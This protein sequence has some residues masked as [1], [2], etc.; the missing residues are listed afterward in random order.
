MVEYDVLCS[1]SMEP[2]ITCVD[3]VE[4]VQDAP[5]DIVV[6]DILVYRLGEQLI[7][8]R[9]ALITDES[10]PRYLMRGD[11]E[12]VHDER[13]VRASQVVGEVVAVRRNSNPGNSGTRA[14]VN[15]ARRAHVLAQAALQRFLREHCPGG[16]CTSMANHRQALALT[17]ESRYRT[18]QYNGAIQEVTS[19]VAALPCPAPSH[20]RD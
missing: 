7:L 20:L 17:D 5:L 3:T 19:G 9:V 11:N 2:A 16:E 1:G 12:D 8:H 13:L 14:M 10:P 6:G 18:C 4:V 15:N